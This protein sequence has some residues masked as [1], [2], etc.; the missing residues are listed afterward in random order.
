MLY[1][2]E[3]VYDVTRRYFVLSAADLL[4]GK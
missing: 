3:V 2:D 4:L 1:S